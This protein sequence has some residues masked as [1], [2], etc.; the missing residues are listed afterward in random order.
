MNWLIGDKVQLRPVEPEDMD[1]LL[2]WENNREN[3]E[4]SGTL[5]PFSRELM[6]RYIENVHL[7]VYQTGQYRF[8]IVEKEKKDPV[9]TADIF[10]FDPF[11]KRAGIGILIAESGQRNKGLATESIELLKNYCFGHLDLRQLYCNIMAD[12]N[13]S[14][15]LFEKSG[16]SVSGTK[17]QWIRRGD[18]YK[19][20]YLLQLIR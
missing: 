6:R 8:V 10:D 15:S 7:N 13:A 3:W 12:N 16:F 20:E 14:I 18:E 5:A 17:K 2:N 1:L 4:I 19:D 9:G 11:H